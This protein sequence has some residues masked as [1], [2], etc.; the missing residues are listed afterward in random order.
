MKRNNSR[1]LQRA[2]N[3]SKFTGKII[4]DIPVVEK[5]TVDEFFQDSGDKL[6][7][8]A[9]GIEQNVVDNYG[10]GRLYVRD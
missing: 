7:K 10:Y 8:N 1:N 3:V 9:L 6:K 2:G 5:G 4:G